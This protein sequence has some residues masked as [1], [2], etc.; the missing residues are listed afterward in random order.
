MRTVD[1]L[2]RSALSVRYRMIENGQ[3]PTTGV[4]HVTKDEQ[5]LLLDQPPL[6]YPAMNTERDRLCGLELKVI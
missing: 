4:F 1:E 6:N 3:N 5:M 2:I